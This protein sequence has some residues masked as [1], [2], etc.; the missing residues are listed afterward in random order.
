MVIVLA[1]STL[2][3]IPAT[4]STDWLAR[5]GTI[6]YAETLP[7]GAQVYLDAVIVDKIKAH[8]KPAYFVIHEWWDPSSRMIVAAQP[9]KDLGM[10]Q[11]VDVEG[12]L[13]TLPTG[14]RAIV[15]PKVT[16]YL[17]V[18]G[19]LVDAPIVKGLFEPLSWPWK[20]DL[21]PD[22]LDSF[23]SMESSVS[24]TDTGEGPSS[25]EPPSSTPLAGE[26]Y[27]A[28]IGD[29][30][31]AN[32][33][34]GTVIELQC[35]RI[36][37]TGTDPTYGNYFVMGE[38]SAPETLK[39]YY[40]SAVTD[41]DRVNKVSGQLTTEGGARV[42]CVNGGPGYD[43]QGYVG[44]LLA[45]PQGTIAW[46]KT[47]AD[48]ASLPSALQDK[49]VSRAFPSEGYFYIQESDRS[50][51][52]RVND[53]DIA[54]AVRPG[55]SVTIASGS[56]TTSDS[57]RVINTSGTTIG[58]P[59]NA[60]RPTGLITRNLGGRDFNVFTPGPAGSHGLNNVGLL[61]RIWGKITDVDFGYFYMDDGS[62]VTDGGT[63]AGVRVIGLDGYQPYTPAVGDYVAVTGI[64]GLAT[65]NT[66][67]GLARTIR[68]ASSSDLN[69]VQ[70][71][72]P[73]TE[74][75]VQATGTDANGYGKLTVYWK[76]VPDALGYN[77]YRGTTSGG[78]DYQ[79]PINGSIPWNTPSYPDS[80][81]YAFT[82]TGLTFGQEYF[83]TVKAVRS[84]GESLPSLEDSDV[85]DSWAIPWDTDDAWAITYAVANLYGYYADLIC[86][87]GPDDTIYS[88]WE[89]V[90]R[91]GGPVDLGT[92]EPGTNILRYSDG[93][94]LTLPDDGGILSGDDG[95]S[96]GMQPMG[97]IPTTALNPSD[98][99]YRRVRSTSSCTASHGVFYP[100]WRNQI[101]MSAQHPKDTYWT[102][103]GSRTV[104]GS[105]KQQTVLEIDAGLQWSRV[106]YKYNPHLSLK[107]KRYD[108]ANA[109]TLAPKDWPIN[110][111]ASYF[112][113]IELFYALQRSGKSSVPMILFY[114]A[115]QNWDEAT[116]LLAAAS[117]V[118][119]T[120]GIMKRAHSIAQGKPP[121][122]YR[123]TGSYARYASFSN[124][125][126]R[127]A[128]G[129]WVT[130][131]DG[132]TSDQGAYPWPSS[133]VTWTVPPGKE[134]FEE[135]NIS[136]NL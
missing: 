12:I 24:S 45:A 1:I 76:A 34:D 6:A 9:S 122:R 119:V 77:I 116:V 106:Y 52:I 60:P 8:Q 64:S 78:E 25:P 74:V 81:K 44:T 111:D 29:L 109:R 115:D 79:N 98:G 49:V 134:Y 126:L 110:F 84:T 42:L 88:S 136:I 90:L 51:G 118:K 128:S 71:V 48:G 43:P 16:G 132:L 27:Y 47:F 39:T 91:P 30:L 127:N 86:A 93:S 130:W 123:L 117:P 13:D 82:D 69:V 38:D 114:G 68:V 23:S 75:E 14:E 58:V 107:Y 66:E 59:V 87:V 41:T 101:Y 83:Y 103:L 100:G 125:M 85:P 80:S 62:G 133:I 21:S 28:T 22:S 63:A 120:S 7:D 2:L 121:N 19:D 35:K 46:A 17:N 32:L 65:Y 131:T 11:M 54:F 94:T 4:A 18:A 92:L 124:G 102:Y 129:Q 31:A 70:Y 50:M 112:G 104:I 67:Y 105:G 96:S 10:R 15:N 33:P 5:P 108:G 95:E 26:T 72:G 61:V 113:G 57:E 37:T 40:S 135:N 73:P 3:P 53:A 99:P 97:Q 89:G 20:T 56:L 55:D 36:V